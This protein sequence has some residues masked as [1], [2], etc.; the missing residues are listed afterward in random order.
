MRSAFVLLAASLMTACGGGSSDGIGA[1]SPDGSTIE[2]GSPSTDAGLLDASK[3]IT[4]AAADADATVVAL[5][6][7]HFVGCF[8]ATD[9]MGPSSEWSGSDILTH[10][11]GTGIAVALHGSANQFAV[12]IDHGAQSVLKF[13]GATTM[14]T[15]ASGLAAGAHDLELS[16]R[17]EASFYPVE[18]GGFTVTGGSI[19]PTPFPYARR[20]ELVGDSITCGY[21]DE[22]MG[23]NCS[24]SADTEDEYLA[25]G[26]LTART[27]GAAHV[28]ISWSGK[29]MSRNYDGTTT[30]TM[31]MLYDLTLPT[32]TTSAWD[33]SKYTPDVVVID[34]GTNDFATGDPGQAYVSAYTA[35][36]TTL[37]GYYPNAFIVCALG[38][39]LGDPNLTTARGYIQGVV[40]ARTAAGDS[41]ISFVE[42]TPQNGSLGYGCDYHPT[43]ATQ[44]Q[45]S[46]TLVAAIQT[47]TGW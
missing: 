37:R 2:G 45:M 42:F 31:P 30:A 32:D 20:I 13:D 17:T 12:S 15:L 22:G 5:E 35:F 43:L 9:P 47:L 8:D 29:G 11:N 4:D 21:G 7:V 27:L 24:F 23:P 33:T 40:S 44:Q 46:T 14:N 36:V 18:F 25:Y 38:P 1:V 3:P 6:P 16:R 10:F 28:S 34:L 39:M 41:R 19:V 26:A